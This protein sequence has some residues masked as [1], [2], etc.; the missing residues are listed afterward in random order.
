MAKQAG[1][2]GFSNPTMYRSIEEAA[3]GEANALPPPG[4]TQTELAWWTGASAQDR[5]DW[6][7]NKSGSRPADV[8]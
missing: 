8:E 3:L 7:N 6:L 4:L 2:G 1:D 5:A